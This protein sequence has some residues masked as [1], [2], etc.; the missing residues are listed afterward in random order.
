MYTG[1]NEADVAVLMRER[2]ISNN[3]IFGPNGTDSD[4]DLT[5]DNVACARRKDRTAGGQHGGQA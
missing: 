1:L 3:T 5:E 2:G 4:E